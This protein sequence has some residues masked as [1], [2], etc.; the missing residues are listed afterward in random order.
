VSAR[1]RP[2]SPRIRAARP[3]FRAAALV[4]LLATGGCG[5]GSAPPAQ[6]LTPLF[7]GSRVDEARATA[8]H[9][10]AQADAA[11]EA[12]ASAE[13]AGRT[14]EAA[15]LAT[16]ARLW[17]AAA[18]AVTDQQAFE[19]EREA[20][21]AATDVARQRAVALQLERESVV[22]EEAT[23]RAAALASESAQRAF[24]HAAGYEARRL[25]RDDPETRALYRET[26]RA[27][28]ERSAA[29]IAASRA[30]GAPGS[31]AGALE[32]R[33]TALRRAP[34]PELV[35]TEADVLL[36]D[37]MALLGR[38]RAALPVSAT[39]AA[40]LLEAAR[41][42]GLSPTRGERGIE[43]RGAP[44]ERPTAAGLRQVAA[45]LNAHPQG[46]VQILVV[47]PVA[48]RSSGRRRAAS[49]RAGLLAGGV[50]AERL[51]VVEVTVDVETPAL[52]LLLPAY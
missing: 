36:S 40:A 39:E 18:L 29:L 24:E 35:V 23:A 28:L 7:E 26:S 48:Q 1:L 52:G 14:D 33:L 49:L 47:G 16:E 15:E 44:L 5:A 50:P 10:M 19:R 20:D 12:A 43:L 4:A 6:T 51:S 3:G 9:L 38:A 42:R 46:G 27:L 25:R 17:L 8:P 34:R 11:R 41:E 2:T 32:E 37:A 30:L 31:A 21:V 45:L 22:E 13:R